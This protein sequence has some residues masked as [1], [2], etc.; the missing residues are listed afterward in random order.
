M[1][2]SELPPQHFRKKHLQFERII[3]D[4]SSRFIHLPSNHLDDEIEL[5]LK[6]VLEFFQVDRCGL[7]R[8]LPDED[9]WEITH[10]AYSEY[11]DPVPVGTKLPR[12]IHPW[13]YEKLAIK[14]EVVTF[15]KVSDTPDEAQV[16]RQ[17]WKDWGIRSNLVIPILKNRSVVHVIAINAMQKERIWPEEYIPRL[18]LLGEIFV[19]AFERRTAEQALR[20]SISRLCLAV[21]SA[22]AGLWEL[23][24]S[25]EIFWASDQARSIFGYGPEEIISME[26]FE[27]SIH[28]EDLE[29]VRQA[30]A[31]TLNDLEPVDIEYRIVSGDGRLKW[32]ASRGR[33]HF[34]PT[35]VPDRVLGVSVDISKRKKMEADLNDRLSEIKKL[36]QQLEDENLYLREDLR[37]ERGFQ[38]IV[39]DS[40]ELKSVLFAAKQVAPTDATVLI[41]GETGTGKGMFANAIHQLSA[42][43]DRPL[44]TVNCSAL[45]HNLIESE[46]FGR[47]KGAFTGAYASQAGRFEVA[48]GGT[49]FLDE[50]GEMPLEI[51]SKFLRVLQEGEFE[52]LGSASTVKVNVRVIAATSRDLKQE[53]RSGRFREDLYYRLNVFPLLI[54]PLRQRRED[55]PLLVNCFTKIYTAKMDKT[56]ISIPQ[57]TMDAFKIYD[58]PG[59]VRELQHIVERSVI[60][61]RGKVL[62]L[63]C[64]LS[65]STR[66]KRNDEP[67]KDLATVE[68]EYI[69]KVL[70]ET[71]WKIEGTAGAA[72]ILKLPPST[73][74]SRIRKLGITRPV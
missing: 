37:I 7:L 4:L 20:K 31:Q 51:Q 65:A 69:L 29:R 52:R 16:D 38:K 45:P 60:V 8:L 70:K 5:A 61:S 58:W 28:P 46:L 49:I 47:E 22:E 14:G 43:K 36:K 9:A 19:S 48:N 67:L 66:C 26:R 50:I 71:G 73:L 68:R 74:R 6:K 1:T 54:P 62:K 12:S 15:S 44:I 25:T 35:G 56:I 41:L 17:T 59:N 32:I 39:G 3:S 63:P 33:L 23:N 30:I 2:P 18:Q 34:D 27:D 21:D 53:V 57:K 13:A 40:K 24:C 10:I 55:I 11:A 42:R 64:Q 72:S